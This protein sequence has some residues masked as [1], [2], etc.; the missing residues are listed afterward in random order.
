MSK[1]RFVRLFTIPRNMSQLTGFLYGWARATTTAKAW[2]S[3]DGGKIFRR[4]K[5]KI[6]GRVLF[7]RGLMGS[8][9]RW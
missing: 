4:Y 1:G 3:L 6:V 9:W 5:N 2:L 7:R 8:F